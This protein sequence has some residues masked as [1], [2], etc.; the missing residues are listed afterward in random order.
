MEEVRLLRVLFDINVLLDV[1][2]EREPWLAKA[3]ALWTAQHRRLIHG[4]VAA[5]GVANMF[6]IARKVI[7]VS[8]A[9]ES[10]GLCLQTFDII[11]IGRAELEL[12]DSLAGSDIED[13]L[14][15]ACASLAKMDAIV[16]RDP[17]GFPGSQIPILSPADLLARITTSPEA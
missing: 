4:H 3:R 2:L 13:N 5:H 17:K 8:R 16:T 15:L 9:R 14:V 12:A 6:Y 10:V 1:F 11:S 7:G